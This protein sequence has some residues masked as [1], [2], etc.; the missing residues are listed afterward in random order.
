MAVIK[1]GFLLRMADGLFLGVEVMQKSDL[2]I[3][4]AYPGNTPDWKSVDPVTFP[5]VGEIMADLKARGRE[6]PVEV[7]WVQYTME[8]EYRAMHLEDFLPKEVQS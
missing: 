2:S 5:R 7:A 3:R 6:L 4:F 8:V 1:E